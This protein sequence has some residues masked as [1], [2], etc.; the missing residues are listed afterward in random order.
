MIAITT[1]GALPPAIELARSGGDKAASLLPKAASLLQNL[2][3]HKDNGVAIALA[4]GIPVLVALAESGPA[5]AR[6]H[7][8]AALE[9]LAQDVDIELRIATTRG[10]A[11]LVDMARQGG[12]FK[13]DAAKD[14]AKDKKEAREPKKKTKKDDERKPLG[15]HALPNLT[16]ALEILAIVRVSFNK[17][18]EKRRRTF[19]R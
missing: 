6:A 14:A 4:G 9:N 1:A 11:A 17:K 5:G 2:A 19:K 16:P 12:F 8:A 7:A 15:V 13:K 18:Q 10:T 3:C